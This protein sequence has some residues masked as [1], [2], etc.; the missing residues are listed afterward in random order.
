MSKAEKGTET[1]RL[2][3]EKRALKLA[4]EIED[5]TAAPAK[6]RLVNKLTKLNEELDSY[7]YDDPKIN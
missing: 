4:N 6:L 2:D 5:T 1:Y 3:L 7:Y